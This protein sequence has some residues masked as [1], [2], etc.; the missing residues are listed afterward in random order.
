[1]DVVQQPEDLLASDSPTDF[2]CESDR[3]ASKLFSMHITFRNLL[4]VNLKYPREISPRENESTCMV[5]LDAQL[6][7]AVSN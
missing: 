2:L 6:L 3:L 1:M 5:K 7:C 4:V